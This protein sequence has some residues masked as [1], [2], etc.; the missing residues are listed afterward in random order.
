MALTGGLHLSA[1]REGERR[2]AGGVAVWAIGRKKRREK[3]KVTAGERKKRRGGLREAGLK[4]ERVR[5]FG[6]LGFYCF[7]FSFF[8]N[9]QQ[10][11]TK[12]TKINATLS[13]I[14]LI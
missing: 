3:R 8:F 5:G 1:A 13:H 7:F 4:Q 12:T 10:P 9:T 14:Y 2:W 11:K 6:G